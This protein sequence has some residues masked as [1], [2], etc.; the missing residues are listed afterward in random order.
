MK[1][2]NDIQALKWKDKQ[3]VHIISI[4]QKKKKKMTE[5]NRSKKKKKIYF[6][7]NMYY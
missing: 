3:D 1:S 7:A 6:Q 2:C 4:K 5:R